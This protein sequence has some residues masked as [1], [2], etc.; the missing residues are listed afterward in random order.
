M[1]LHNSQYTAGKVEGG[2]SF[3][4]EYYSTVRK[5]EN[6]ES[7]ISANLRLTIITIFDHSFHEMPSSTVSISSSTYEGDQKK[8]TKNGI[9]GRS[10]WQRTC[11][12]HD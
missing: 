9:L 10:C 11:R 6:Y 8:S 3:I 1:L 4:F 7:R 5:I 2:Y 12:C